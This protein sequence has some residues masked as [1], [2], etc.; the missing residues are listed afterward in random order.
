MFNIYLTLH[1]PVIMVWKSCLKIDYQVNSLILNL[2]DAVLDQI[3]HK[4]C[5]IVCYKC[6]CWSNL[7]ASFAS[8]PVR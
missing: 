7:A 4:L 6:H 1:E 3:K 5:P 2:I 8:V